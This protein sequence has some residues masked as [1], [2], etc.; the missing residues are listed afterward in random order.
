M[1]SAGRHGSRR[2]VNCGEY[3]PRFSLGNLR[4]V[5]DFSR[6]LT[7]PLLFG[8]NQKVWSQDSKGI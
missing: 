7:T 6:F 8:M 3:Q 1:R 5:P 4:S 2:G